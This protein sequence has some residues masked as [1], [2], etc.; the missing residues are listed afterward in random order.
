MTL[1]VALVACVVTPAAGYLLAGASAGPVLVPLMEAGVAGSSTVYVVASAAYPKG[2]A[3]RACAP[4]PCLRLLRTNDDGA[5][6]TSLHLPRIGYVEGDDTGDLN[7]V[8]FANARD[9]Y[10]VLNTPGPSTLY[11]TTDGARSWHRETIAT[12]A[13]IFGLVA[14]HDELNTVL[15]RCSTNGACTDFRFAR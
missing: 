8:V 10:A 3:P 5:H 12:G 2:A 13:W 1:V 11:V 9:G 15:A 7:R 6:F 4:G 14:S